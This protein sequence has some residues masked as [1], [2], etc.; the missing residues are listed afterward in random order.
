M[1]SLFICPTL[2]ELDYGELSNIYWCQG[3]KIF[4]LKKSLS[5]E[6]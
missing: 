2:E 6:P 3:G 1:H 4:F 5:C